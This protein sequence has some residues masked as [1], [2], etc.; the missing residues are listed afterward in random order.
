MNEYSDS[1]SPL[2]GWISV[3]SLALGLVIGVGCSSGPSRIMP[4]SID[5]DDAA[6]KAMELYDS[7]GDGFIAGEELESTPALKASMETLDTDGDGKVSEDEIEARILVWQGTRAG[8]TTIRCLVTMDG[9]PLEGATVTFEPAEFLKDS[10][11]TAVA[12]T[13]Y[14]GL[15]SPR[16]PKENRPTPDTPPGIQLGFYNVKISKEVNGKETIPARFNE[17]TILGQQVAM[18]DPEIVE[19]RVVFK[20]KS[21]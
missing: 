1:R 16:I 18:D 19:Q 15:V 9:H 12:E 10:I 8:L 11:Q 14:T 5:A 21:K 20:V 13:R 3:S 7:D 2:V 17:E 4:P 6:A